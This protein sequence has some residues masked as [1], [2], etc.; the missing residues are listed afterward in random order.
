MLINNSLALL[1]IFISIL[2][3]PSAIRV[4]LLFLAHHQK[5]VY[6]RFCFFVNA[7]FNHVSSRNTRD[8]SNYLFYWI[9]FIFINHIWDSLLAA[10]SFLS[11]LVIVQDCKDN[12]KECGCIIM[13]IVSLT[14]EMMLL[15]LL[16]LLS[17][18]S[19]SSMIITTTTTTLQV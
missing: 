8:N 16:Q 4:I 14:T 1:C 7:L 10:F 19:S 15:L 2:R 5:S 11:P 17:S 9:L 13:S 3:F 18:S 6:V 12:R